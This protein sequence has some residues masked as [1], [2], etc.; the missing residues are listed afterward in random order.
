MDKSS[1]K[2]IFH[3]V[4]PHGLEDNTTILASTKSFLSTLRRCRS[5]L[6]SVIQETFPW[7]NDADIFETPRLPKVITGVNQTANPEEREDHLDSIFGSFKENFP[8]LSDLDDDSN[9]YCNTLPSHQG[10]W[11]KGP[12]SF[13][14]ADEQI[15][16]SSYTGRSHASKTHSRPRKSSRNKKARVVAGSYNGYSS[17]QLSDS[18]FSSDTR[19]SRHRKSNRAQQIPPTME[20][21]RSAPRS[22]TLTK[23]MN[24]TLSKAIAP[25]TSHSITKTFDPIR[26]NDCTTPSTLT[27]VE[28]ERMQLQQQEISDLRENLQYLSETVLFL[29]S[30]IQEQNHQQ[31]RLSHSVED[32]QNT[33]QEHQGSQNSLAAAV[34][35]L[36]ENQQ[37]FSTSISLVMQLLQKMDIKLSAL[38][39]KTESQPSKTYPPGEASQG[40]N[41]P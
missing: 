26:P 32:I 19:Q 38:P 16:V 13:N 17:G 14:T 37:S 2:R 36:E 1:S 24:D 10:V 20:K 11:T 12:P 33:I 18:D 6:T 9:D 41:A 21:G 5:N 4:T 28:T 23:P 29:Q 35:N 30:S 3:A 25:R 27:A 39:T 8:S 15:D 40:G 34:Q 22:N 31:N 7:V